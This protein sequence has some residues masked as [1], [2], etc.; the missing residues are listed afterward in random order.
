MAVY[1]IREKYK[2]PLKKI[3]EMFGKRDHATIAHGYDKIKQALNVDQ[4]V[5]NDIEY[6]EKKLVE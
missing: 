4:H 6:L 5:K 3:G 2:T 1:L